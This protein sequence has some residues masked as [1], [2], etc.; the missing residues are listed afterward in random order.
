M[1]LRCVVR[2]QKVQDRPSF[3][4]SFLF[5]TNLSHVVHRYPPSSK[6]HLTQQLWDKHS[7]QKRLASAAG[8]WV[9]D[10]QELSSPIVFNPPQCEQRD[11]LHAL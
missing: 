9:D 4:A 3:C 2:P 10:W 1:F 8:E 7:L 5:S 11:F 6:W